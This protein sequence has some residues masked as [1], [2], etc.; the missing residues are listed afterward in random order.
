MADQFR[1]SQLHEQSRQD[2]QA[3]EYG[4]GRGDNLPVG[5]SGSGQSAGGHEVHTRSC[6]NGV[7]SVCDIDDINVLYV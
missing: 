6:S 7:C 1:I 3:N 5:F 4:A 2:E